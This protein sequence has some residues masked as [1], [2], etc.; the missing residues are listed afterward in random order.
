VPRPPP[1]LLTPPE[2][3]RLLAV[4]PRTLWQLTHDGGIPVVRFG[5][6]VR[7]DVRDLLAFIDRAKEGGPK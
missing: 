1:L 7:Y 2:A 4:S 5:R 6:A 3:A